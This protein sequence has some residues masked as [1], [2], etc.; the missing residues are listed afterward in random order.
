MEGYEAVV[1]QVSLIWIGQNDA[2]SALSKDLLKKIM[3]EGT[4]PA[5]P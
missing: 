3:V 2:M 5:P 1:F 4:L